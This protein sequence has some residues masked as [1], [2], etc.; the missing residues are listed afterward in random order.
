LSDSPLLVLFDQVL[1]LSDSIVVKSCAYFESASEGMG[2]EFAVPRVPSK[3]LYAKTA[4]Y[5]K[6]QKGTLV[7]D[8]KKGLNQQG[9]IPYVVR[10]WKKYKAFRDMYTE[11]CHMSVCIKIQEDGFHKVKTA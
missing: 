11:R 3:L 10:Q 4:V 1:A 5:A 9:K 2:A 8:V 7:G 6:H